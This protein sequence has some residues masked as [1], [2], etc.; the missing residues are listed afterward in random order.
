MTSKE[1]FEQIQKEAIGTVIALI[2]LILFWIAAGFGMSQVDLELFG[3]PIWVYTST[4]GVWV[5]ATILVKCLVGLVFKDFSLD[6]EE[7]R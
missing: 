7:A 1:K 4:I 2:V 5:F 3:L 6:E